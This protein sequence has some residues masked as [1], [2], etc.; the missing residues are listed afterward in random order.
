MF[1]KYAEQLVESGHAY[2]CFCDKDRL[3]EVRVLQKASGIAPRYDG[4]CR[5]L[6]K[7]EVAESWRQES[8]CHPAE[9][10]YRG[11]H[12]FPR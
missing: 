3:D 5:N 6:S 7:E 10:A 1:K 2:Y 9:N 12:F 8:L 4:H 11:Y